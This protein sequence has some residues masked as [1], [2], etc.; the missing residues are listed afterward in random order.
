MEGGEFVI[1][2][3]RSLPTIG[4]IGFTEHPPSPPLLRSKGGFRALPPK[5]NS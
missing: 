4:A 2:D 1:I 3:L 5:A